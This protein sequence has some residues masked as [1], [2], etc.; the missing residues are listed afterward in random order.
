MP[1]EPTRRTFMGV[2]AAACAGSAMGSD[3]VPHRHAKRRYHVCL[4]PK[5]LSEHPEL[6]S[7]VQH[8][9]VE[10]IW[11]AGFF[12]G[13]WPAPLDDV[14]AWRDRLKQAGL[15]A[16]LI[17]LALGHPGNSLSAE[18]TSY[19]LSPG[20]HWKMATRFD[21]TPYSGTSLHAPATEEN[22]A[23]M[24]LIAKRDVQTV[25][26]DDDFRLATGPGGIGGCYCDE[27]KQRFL[28]KYGF[29]TT[30]W[31]ILLENVRTRTLTPLLRAWVDFTCDELTACFRAQQAAAPK[32]VLGNMVMYLGAEKAGIRLKDYH[33]VPLRVGELMFDD[34]SF[35]TVQGKTNELF[36]CLFHR[37]YVSPE[38][39][40]SESTAFPADKLSAK[41]MAAKLA[42]STI[43]DVRNTMFMSGVTP[44]PVE[45]WTVLAPAMKKH[46][47]IHEY[48]A[49]HALKGPF[50]HFWGEQQR[51]VGTDQPFSTF[52]ALGVP[53]E[54]VDKPTSLGWTFL[55]DFDAKYAA[56]HSHK[57]ANCIIRSG[58]VS[59]PDSIPSHWHAVED[60]LS[61]L[62]ALK[63]SLL[64]QLTKTPYVIEDKPV[65]CAWYPSA[66][67]VL[68]WNLS[69][70]PETFTLRIPNGEERSINIA[71]LDVELIKEVR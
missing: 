8:A 14:I 61:T 10:K 30:D 70:Q 17:N 64:P 5:L 43:A 45:H 6:I 50:K 67:A 40:Y 53:F 65:V 39:A 4:A 51:F 37:R 52:L 36:S 55:S 31:E 62:F 23:A 9:G 13:F 22:V 1:W 2:C 38:L 35:G 26:L 3:V 58:V 44:F 57:N 48:L 56:S 60:N 11:L 29:P 34:K 68:L 27:H 24:R 18:D 47:S 63:K 66:H 28:K 71:G 12:Y 59:P 7:V 41:N 49:G 54:V 33:G 32:V 20:K 15:D 46:A 16:D 69:E 19:P 42:V 25:F 21:G